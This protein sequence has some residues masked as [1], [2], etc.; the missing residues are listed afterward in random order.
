[1]KPLPIKSF[2][3]LTQFIID[4]VDLLVVPGLCKGQLHDYREPC[5]IGTPG[6]PKVGK[7]DLS[8]LD[9]C[10]VCNSQFPHCAPKVVQKVRWGMLRQ[11]AESISHMSSAHLWYILEWERCQD[12]PNKLN[13]VYTVNSTE[14]NLVQADQLG[15][16]VGSNCPL[17]CPLS[18]R[19]PA[20]ASLDI[21][22]DLWM[23]SSSSCITG[24]ADTTAWPHEWHNLHKLWLGQRG[25]GLCGVC[26]LLF[27]RK[28]VSILKFLLILFF[29]LLYVFS[30]C[31]RL[32]QAKPF[33]AQAIMQVILCPWFSCALQF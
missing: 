8:F 12:V 31:W 3:K 21:G 26:C 23:R 17:R 22:K 24:G 6:Q 13:G 15:I 25:P 18:M 19:S 28:K 20:N 4:C 33:L 14:V 9:G 1:M 11:E 5:L 27:L 32:W 30:P 29:M 7:E 2:R 10:C 16:L